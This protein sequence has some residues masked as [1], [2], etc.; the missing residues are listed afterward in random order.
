MG[1]VNLKWSG[2]QNMGGVLNKA[3]YIP[4]DHLAA[5]PVLSAVGKLKVT[6]DIA[7]L[8][9]KG[10]IEIYS[11]PA[12]NKI[13]DNTVGE[14][15]GMSKENIYECFY[16]GDEEACA[17]FEAEYLNT[18]CVLLIPDTRGRLRIIGLCRLDKAT[19]VL[20]KD[21]PAYMTGSTG[22][23]GAATADLK[24]KTFTFKAFAPHAPLFYTGAV[25]MLE[26]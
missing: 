24:G 6:A 19:T 16:P 1:L 26:A 21:L 15:D 8:A 10:F 3:Y 23:S 25:T 18:P 11:T 9:D 2:Q 14:I 12:K 22:T 17:E 13:D 4:V 20:S 5:L 7:V